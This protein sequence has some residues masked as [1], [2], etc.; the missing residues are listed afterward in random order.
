MIRPLFSFLRDNFAIFDNIFSCL[1]LKKVVQLILECISENI[2][3]N[4]EELVMMYD[5]TAAVL[6]SGAMGK[7]HIKFLSEIVKELII[8]TN[9]EQ[10]G[11]ALAEEY[12]CKLYADYNEMFEREHIDFVSVCLPTYLHRDASVAA[13]EHGINVLCEK[14]FASNAD[15]A[16]EMLERAKAKDLKLM[17]G[18]CERFTRRYEYIRRCVADGRF[19]KV[20]SYTAWREHSM[21]KW[22]I[23]SWLANPALS[24][25]I[26]RDTNIHDTDMIVGLFGAPKSVFTVGCDT[27]CRSVYTYEG[28]AVLTSASWRDV[29]GLPSERGIDVLFEKGFIKNRGSDITVYTPGNSFDPFE[30]EEFS[31]FFGDNAVENEIKYFAHCLVNGEDITICPPEDSFE[32]IKVSC[33]QSESLKGST[34]VIV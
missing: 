29:E 3:K 9:D 5:L 32:S 17:I 22:S 24:G 33:A 12:G 8:C 28:K 4:R 6:G 27:L 31:E 10:T 34:Q 25:G 2:C 14:P 19:G 11:K 20:L 7:H 21:P 16:R 30:V 23:G 13:M 26:V 15:E 18:H 1:D